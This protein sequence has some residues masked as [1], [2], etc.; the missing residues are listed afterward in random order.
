MGMDEQMFGKQLSAG[1]RDNGT[2]NGLISSPPP[3]LSFPKH[4]E[5]TFFAEISG[6]SSILEISPL[7]KFF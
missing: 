7:S 1:Y 5:P 4:T 3:L 2:Q 6:D